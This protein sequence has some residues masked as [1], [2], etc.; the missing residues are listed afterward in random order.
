M[1]NEERFFSTKVLR[2]FCVASFFI[3]HCSFLAPSCT[4]VS[5]ECEIVV[6]PRLMVTDGSDPDTP[7]YGAR[8]YAFYV[9]GNVS[10]I[11]L[12]RP[13]S[14]AD[15]EAGIVT[16]SRTGEVRSFNLV[17]EQVE[18][19]DISLVVSRSPVVLVVVDPS[20]GMWAHRGVEYDIPLARLY[21]TARF[22][23]EKPTP[24]NELEWTVER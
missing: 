5:P 14:R 22:R 4:K 16:N 7:A 23:Q 20:S 13:D 2:N 24:Y 3:L 1:K 8:V 10:D 17:G 9:E 18:S 11:K 19:E 15:A 12:W 21:L 6:R